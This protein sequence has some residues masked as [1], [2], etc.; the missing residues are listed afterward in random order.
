VCTRNS[1]APF[2]PNPRSSQ[3]LAA[4]GAGNAGAMCAYPAVNGVPMCGNSVLLTDTL[5]NEYGMGAWW[6][7]VKRSD[8]L[9]CLGHRGVRDGSQSHDF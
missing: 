3:V 4:N 2:L 9:D 1:V 7:A 6:I 8:V 5:R